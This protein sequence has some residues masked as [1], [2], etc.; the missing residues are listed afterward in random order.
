MQENYGTLLALELAPWVKCHRIGDQQPD[1]VFGIGSSGQKAAF[2]EIS[3]NA[4]F[5][6]RWVIINDR[7]EQR[8][9]IRPDSAFKFRLKVALSF[10]VRHVG[11]DNSQLIIGTNAHVLGIAVH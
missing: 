10:Q 6:A 5:G 2:E 3:R 8:L 1:S 7:T 11:K 4:T 9:S